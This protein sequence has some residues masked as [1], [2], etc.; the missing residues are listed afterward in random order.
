M[1]TLE[2]AIALAAEAHAGQT[3]KAGAPY[4][5]HPLRVM[6]ALETSEERI[7]GVL[8]DVMEDTAWTLEALRAEGF[9][10]EMLAA[11]EA[12]TRRAGEPYEAFVRRAAANPIGRKV[13]RADLCDNL[14]RTRIPH[15]TERDRERWLKYERALALIERIAQFGSENE[16]SA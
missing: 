6:L 4:I 10:P 5:L 2:R 1:S 3:D 7:V 11:L 15:P 14:D 12:V 8:H 13:K 16:A 9:S